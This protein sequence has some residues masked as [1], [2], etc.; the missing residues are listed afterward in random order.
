MVTLATPEVTTSSS[1]VTCTCMWKLTTVF[2]D[3]R[4]WKTIHPRKLFQNYHQ[5]CVLSTDRIKIRQSQ[6][7]AVFPPERAIAGIP[8]CNQRRPPEKWRKSQFSP[9][10]LQGCTQA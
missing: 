3:T 6:P 2:V 1:D 8:R 10:L 4:L 5:S 7:L 9:L